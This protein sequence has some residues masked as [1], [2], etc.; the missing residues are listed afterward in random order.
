MSIRWPFMLKRT[1]EDYAKI[2]LRDIDAWTDIA[3]KRR[4]KIVSLRNEINHL[5]HEIDSLQLNLKRAKKKST[6]RDP[7]TG[8]LVKPKK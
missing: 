8:R 2:A 3:T 1:C 6:Y 7:Q 4:E 5:H